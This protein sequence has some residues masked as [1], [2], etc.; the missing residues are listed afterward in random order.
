MPRTEYRGMGVTRGAAPDIFLI[1]S[2]FNKLTI[3]NS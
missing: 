1:F 3:K 2:H